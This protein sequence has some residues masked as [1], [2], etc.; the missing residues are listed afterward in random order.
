MIFG[1]FQTSINQIDLVR[2]MPWPKQTDYFLV[3]QEGSQLLEIVI[4]ISNV[5]VK[6]FSAKKKFFSKKLKNN[7]ISAILF[8]QLPGPDWIGPVFFT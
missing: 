1:S 5:H 6:Q 8:F 7:I 4:F 2:T 3:G